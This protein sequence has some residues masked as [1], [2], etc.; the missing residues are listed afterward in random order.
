[1][2]LRLRVTAARREVKR[3]A[4][5]AERR[6]TEA[7]SIRALPSFP[8][9]SENETETI[10]GGEPLRHS[11]APARV[12]SLPGEA[13]ERLHQRVAHGLRRAGLGAG[14]F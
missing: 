3:L 4:A 2:N 5:L 6:A 14:L 10:M 11:A 12:L 7:K 9:L 13:R 8:P 1:M